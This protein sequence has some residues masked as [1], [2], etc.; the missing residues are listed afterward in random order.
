MLSCIVDVC[1]IIKDK[2]YI[3][4]TNSP[5]IFGSTLTDIIG[6]RMVDSFDFL[7]LG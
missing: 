3:V 4:V 5:P 1:D 2:Q 6:L 7:I